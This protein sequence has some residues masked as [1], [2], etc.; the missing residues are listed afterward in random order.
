MKWAL[1]RYIS[2]RNYFQTVGNG[3]QYQGFKLNQDYL[4]NIRRYGVHCKCLERS[5]QDHLSRED[6]SVI[7]K[8]KFITVYI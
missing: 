2:I 6:L 4:L 3:S 5:K 8:R 1:A 7:I